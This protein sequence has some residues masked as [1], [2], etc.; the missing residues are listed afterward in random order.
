M[1]YKNENLKHRLGVT[2]AKYKCPKCNKPLGIDK[3]KF[4]IICSSCNT[5]IREKELL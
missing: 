1:G 4:M 5:L 2:Q 3:P